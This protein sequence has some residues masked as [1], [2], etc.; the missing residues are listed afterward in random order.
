MQKPENDLPI[1][2]LENDPIISIEEQIII[3]EWT[4]KNHDRFTQ[5]GFNRKAKR[6][7]LLPD[8]P[9]IAFAIKKRLEEKENLMK[10]KEEPFFGNVIAFMT[11]GGQL[12]KHVDPN[13]DKNQLIH[14]RFNIYVQIP[15][16]GGLPVYNNQIIKLEERNYVCCRS[17]LDEHYCLKV[18]GEK[19]RIVLSFGYLIPKTEL[20]D[21]N[22]KYKI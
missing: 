3:I 15:L 18:E 9:E 14:V 5:N 20:N 17:G 11:E 22:L 21:I 7:D 6:L 8:F 2:I 12:H 19:E 13:Q 10:Y 1:I 16:K 4:K